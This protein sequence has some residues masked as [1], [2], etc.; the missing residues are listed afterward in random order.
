ME[1]DEAEASQHEAEGEESADARED[2][3]VGSGAGEEGLQ[4]GAKA[5]RGAALA[6]SAEDCGECVQDPALERAVEVM[7]TELIR[8]LREEGPSVHA[9][10]LLKW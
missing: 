7:V 3:A 8:R 5:S 4:S 1:V 2:L 9:E 10:T 6:A